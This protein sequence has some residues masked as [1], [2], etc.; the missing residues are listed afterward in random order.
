MLFSSN[1]AEGYV[2]VR[3]RS[4][5]GI[6]LLVFAN[7]NSKRPKALNY[8]SVLFLYVIGKIIIKYMLDKKDTF[9]LAWYSVQ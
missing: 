7:V 6:M 4:R 5:H 3:T 9:N 1:A 2:M 8:L